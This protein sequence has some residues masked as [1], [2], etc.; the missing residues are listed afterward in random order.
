MA[1][2]PQHCGQYKIVMKI[3][4]DVTPLMPVE[5][6]VDRYL[7]Q[8]VHSL[9]R[10]DTRNRYTIFINIGDLGR[11]R[12]LGPNFSPFHAGIRGLPGRLIAQ[13]A[14]VPMLARF[15]QLD[16]LHSPS[17]FIPILHG[18]TKQV[19][20]VHDM[21]MFSLGGCHSRLRR[22]SIFLRGVSDSIRHSHLVIVPSFFVRQEIVRLMPDVSPAKVK[23]TPCGVDPEFQPS[24]DESTPLPAE[25]AS[26][27]PYILFVGTIEP[28]KNLLLLLEAYR[29]AI[30]RHGLREHLL[31]VGRKGWNYDLVERQLQSPEL[32]QRVCAAGYVGRRDLLHL[33][34]NASVFVCPSLQEGFGLPPLEAMACGIPTIATETSSL[35]ENLSGAAIL[36]PVDSVTA[37][38]DALAAASNQP[39]MRARLRSQGL[40]RA[41][42]FSWENT[43]RKTLECYQGL[44]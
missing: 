5:T 26:L 13:Q 18:R 15:R 20:T 6:G 24:A 42:Q 10:I 31:L 19:V 33:Y 40:A 36:V 41:R 12:G 11:F 44:A 30:A 32:R 1:G 39:E 9:A 21:T 29:E 3:G 27:R 2:I 7:L 38:A 28:R 37:L 22:S 34:Q 4:I 23:V 16:V 8:L 25:L 14:I 43:A 17:F 35:K